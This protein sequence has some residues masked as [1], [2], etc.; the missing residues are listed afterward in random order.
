MESCGVPVDERNDVRNDREGLSLTASAELPTSRTPSA[1]AL[2][3]RSYGPPQ[4]AGASRTRAPDVPFS[5]RGSAAAEIIA[6]SRRSGQFAPSRSDGVGRR[7]PGTGRLGTNAA[8]RIQRWAPHAPL[9]G[10]RFPTLL[11]GAW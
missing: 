4:I 11:L 10:A 7:R 3:S 6:L 5:A 8:A 2:P 1:G 9:R